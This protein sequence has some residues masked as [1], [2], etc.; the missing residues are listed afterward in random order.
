MKE[1][2]EVVKEVLEYLSN[3]RYEDKNKE[4]AKVQLMYFI[5]KTCSTEEKLEKSSELLEKSKKLI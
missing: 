1:Y 3:K 2:D 4:F 5:Y